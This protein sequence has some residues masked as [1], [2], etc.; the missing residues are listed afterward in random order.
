ME[1]TEDEDMSGMEASLIQQHHCN[2]GCGN[3]LTSLKKEN[4][5]LRKGHRTLCKIH[6]CTFIDHC[7][8]CRN[9]LKRQEQLESQQKAD[10]LLEKREEAFKAEVVDFEKSDEAQAFREGVEAIHAYKLLT[11]NQR[12][13]KEIQDEKKRKAMEKSQKMAERKREAEAMKAEREEQRQVAED[14]QREEEK[15]ARAQGKG[16]KRQAGIQNVLAQ[17][18]N[19]D[20]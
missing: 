11:P 16:G 9:D 5:C 10:K 7:I 13:R 20:G 4:E 6:K 18:P 1:L 2:K 17:R 8:Q 12:K 19:G 3:V 14:R 15:R